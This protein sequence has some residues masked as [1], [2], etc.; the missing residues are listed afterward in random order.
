MMGDCLVDPLPRRVSTTMRI[1]STGTHF[2]RRD[3]DGN[4]SVITRDEWRRLTFW[5][6]TPIYDQV[7]DDLGACLNCRCADCGCCYGCGQPDADLFGSHG[8][9]AEYGG[10]V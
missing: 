8:Y 4:L 2:W 3:A 1:D 6:S 7:L 9:G 10:C 5:P